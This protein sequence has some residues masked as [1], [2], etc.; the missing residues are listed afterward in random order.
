MSQIFTE[1]GLAVPVTIVEAPASVVTQIRTEEKDGYSAVQ[2]GFETQKEKNISKAQKGA[3]K[4]LG[5]FKVIREF[6]VSEVT[7]KEGDKIDVSVFEVGDIVNVSGISKGKGFQGAVKRW[8]FSGGRRTHG[9]KHHERTV[10]S[11]GST[12]PARVFKGKKMAGRMGSDR[13][14]VKN[15]QV[16]AVDADNNLLMIKGALPGKPGTLLEIRSKA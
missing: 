9:N 12:G 7:H 11:I 15:L 2:L 1:D 16:V 10:G 14:T 4:D 13:T 6:R 8:N 3:W 5:L